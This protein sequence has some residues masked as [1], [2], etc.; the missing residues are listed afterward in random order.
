MDRKPNAFAAICLQQ[1]SI[2]KATCCDGGV[3][4]KEAELLLRQEFIAPSQ[5]IGRPQRHQAKV[6]SAKLGKTF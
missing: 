1:G 5:E 6:A 3:V 2:E 4:P